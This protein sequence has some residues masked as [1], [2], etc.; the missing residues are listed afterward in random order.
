VKVNFK[1]FF[2]HIAFQYSFISLYFSAP[3]IKTHLKMFTV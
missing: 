1:I 2:K 3:K